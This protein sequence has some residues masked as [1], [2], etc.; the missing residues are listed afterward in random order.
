MT[1]NEYVEAIDQLIVEYT[2]NLSKKTLVGIEKSIEDADVGCG[3]LW[4][5]D[6]VD[7]EYQRTQL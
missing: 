6:Y 2:K 3:K 7:E 4:L 1:F 5:E